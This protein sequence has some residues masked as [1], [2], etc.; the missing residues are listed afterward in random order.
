MPHDQVTW[1][2]LPEASS[3]ENALRRN[4]RPPSAIKGHRDL[5]VWQRAMDLVIEV[6]R[7]SKGFP[8]DERYALVQQVRRAA[9]SI[10]ANIA[11]G[12][13]SR[14]DRRGRANAFGPA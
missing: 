12:S 11:E 1:T 9:V 5:L 2:R 8:A 6:Y 4:D 10:P 14:P 3:G 7:L 13:D